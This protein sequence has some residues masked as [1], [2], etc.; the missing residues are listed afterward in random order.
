MSAL[1]LQTELDSSVT[2]TIIRTVTLTAALVAL[3][4]HRDHEAHRSG[5]AN[6]E[7]SEQRA[8]RRRL[9]QARLHRSGGDDYRLFRIY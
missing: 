2:Q 8:K 4:A 7:R 6:R 3:N 5:T 9:A 1:Q